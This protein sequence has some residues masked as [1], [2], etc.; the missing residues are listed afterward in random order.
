M[1]GGEGGDGSHFLPQLH[2][3]LTNVEEVKT[4]RPHEELCLLPACFV[5][6]CFVSPET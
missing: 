4:D 1:R 3:W 6:F 2:E 5:F